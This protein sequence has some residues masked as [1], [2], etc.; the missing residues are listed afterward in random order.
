[1]PDWVAEVK[2]HPKVGPAA[3][4]WVRAP[5]RVNL[6]GEHTDYTEGFVLPAAID[7]EIRGIVSP[8]A[9]RMVRVVS[10]AVDEEDSY[11]LGHEGPPTSRGWSN[12]VRGVTVALHEAGVVLR[13][14]FELVLGST[15]PVAAGLSSSAALEAAVA[16]AALAINDI[17][18]DPEQLAPICRR[19]EN[20]YVGV[21]C[22]VMDQMIVLG[23]RA[24][25]AMMLDCRS[26]KTSAV[27]IPDDLAIVVCDTGADRSLAQSAYNDR[28]EECGQ[29]LDIL[30][31]RSP[32]I[33]S[34]RDASP[35]LVERCRSGL[36][37]I[38]YR[39]CRHVVTENARV[40]A[41]V[42]ALNGDD[43]RAI[44]ELMARSHASLRDDYE[45]SSR[46]LDAM[47]EVAADCPGFVGGRLTGA[48]FGGC[49]VNLVEESRVDDFS[50]EV[51]ERFQQ[52]TDRPALVYVCEAAAGAT[53]GAVV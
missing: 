6:I 30:R 45:V 12:Y 18:A 20:D 28:L 37:S 10:L 3:S 36:G 9:D 53:L 35:D 4:H 26:L 31:R 11:R 50:R 8:F 51:A 23:G 19:A 40:T 47:V 52:V 48:G 27:P 24:G 7:L 16:L 43:R 32:E 5:G 21:G 29:G 25:H 22:G 33:R 46:D 17:R 41:L 42:D 49:T 39:R 38:L 1:M 13:Q 15:L 14:G 44:A 34:L 2:A